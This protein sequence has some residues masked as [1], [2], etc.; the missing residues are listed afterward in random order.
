MQLALSGV[1]AKPV[2]ER[3]A[4]DV[5]AIDERHVGGVQGLCGREHDLA[6]GDVA[7]GEEPGVGVAGIGT[8]QLG[9]G[10]GGHDHRQPRLRGVAQEGLCIVGVVGADDGMTGVVAL[11]GVG[12]VEGQLVQVFGVLVVVAQV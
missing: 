8:L 10:T 7:L 6:L 5:V 9:T 3:L 2:H 11:A 12:E 4:V 1:V